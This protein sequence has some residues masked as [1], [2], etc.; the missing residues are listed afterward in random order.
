[1]FNEDT[2][3]QY[4]NLIEDYIYPALGNKE[5]KHLT[6]EHYV[7]LLDEIKRQKFP[8]YKKIMQAL[9]GM[10]EFAIYLKIVDHNPLKLITK[11]DLPKITHVEKPSNHVPLPDLINVFSKLGDDVASTMVKIAC[12][13]VRRSAKIRTMEWNQ[14]DLNSGVWK[15]LD[16]KNKKSHS[17]PLPPAGV[18]LLQKQHEVTGNQRYVFPNPSSKNGIHHTNVILNKLKD[19]SDG[20]Q[21]TH[22]LRHAFKTWSSGA[23]YPQ[24]IRSVQLEHDKEGMSRTYDHAEF[25]YERKIMMEHWQDLLQGKA[26]LNEKARNDLS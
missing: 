14:I 23:G 19:L 17:T 16:S 7:L 22:G 21:T 13:S 6:K 1:M 3:R 8:T 4:R 26:D 20:K 5:L 25:L 15:I 24:D 9:N 12:F 2:A 10:Y 18:K 11:F